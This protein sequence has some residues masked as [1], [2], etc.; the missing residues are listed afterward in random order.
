MKSIQA[1]VRSKTTACH[2]I[3]FNAHSRKCL[4]QGFAMLQMK[5]LLFELVRRVEW[6]V[7]PGY[8]LKLTSV[9]SFQF[10]SVQFVQ[11]NSKFQSSNLTM[12]MENK[13][14]EEVG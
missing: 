11:S 2:Y 4:G 10:S 14:N 9:S 1:A 7:H 12:D 3:A 5:V 13:W 8:E 6:D